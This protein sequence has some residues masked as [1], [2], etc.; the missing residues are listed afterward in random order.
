M[1]AFNF[2]TYMPLCGRYSIQAWLNMHLK[3]HLLEIM[4][5][6]SKKTHLLMKRKK[7]RK[8]EIQNECGICAIELGAKMT[9]LL[10]KYAFRY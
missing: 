1:K 3:K 5:N 7:L 9:Q 10:I 4:N 2:A 8:Y 6:F